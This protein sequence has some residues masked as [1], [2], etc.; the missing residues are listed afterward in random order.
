MISF[1][2]T[3]FLQLLGVGVATS[4]RS[5]S[6][7]LVYIARSRLHAAGIDDMYVTS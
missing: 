4:F 1:A 2:H 5:Y 3:L 6:S 7:G